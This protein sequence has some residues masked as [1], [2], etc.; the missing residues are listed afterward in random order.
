MRYA[1]FPLHL[2][3]GKNENRAQQNGLLTADSTGERLKEIN[4]YSVDAVSSYQ[5][6]PIDRSIGFE[7]SFDLTRTNVEHVDS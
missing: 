5:A 1:L 7:K 3:F 6:K 2:S 4:R